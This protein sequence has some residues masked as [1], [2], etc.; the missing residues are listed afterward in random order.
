MHG[1]ASPIFPIAALVGLVSPVFQSTKIPSVY[2][3]A[4]IFLLLLMWR[5][6]LYM[7]PY[8]A[9]MATKLGKRRI[10]NIKSGTRPTNS[11]L[12]QNFGRFQIREQ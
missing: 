9:R 5:F 11:S 8:V 1:F 10:L 12:V 7:C 3:F 6:S 4:T 2:M